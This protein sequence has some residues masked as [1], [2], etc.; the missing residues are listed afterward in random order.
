MGPANY[1]DGKSFYVCFPWTR[2]KPLKL[3]ILRLGVSKIRLSITGAPLPSTRLVSTT[4]TFNESLPDSGASFITMQWG[5]F[6]DHD[7][8]QTAGTTTSKIIDDLFYILYVSINSEG[9]VSIALNFN[10]F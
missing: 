6:L 3:S 10:L 8:T 4:V 1:A 7:L 5:Q 2:L 9:R